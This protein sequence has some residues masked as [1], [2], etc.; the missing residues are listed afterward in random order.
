MPKGFLERNGVPPFPDC[1]PR[2]VTRSS[3]QRETTGKLV[4]GLDLTCASQCFSK[5][6]ETSRGLESGHL[7]FS[8]AEGGRSRAE[9]GRSSKGVG[10]SE[11]T[12]L[13]H[14]SPWFVQAE[15]ISFGWCTTCHAR[16]LAWNPFPSPSP[17]F[18]SGRCWIRAGTQF[19]PSAKATPPRRWQ[20]SSQARP[21]KRRTLMPI[22]STRSS[23]PHL[24]IE[25]PR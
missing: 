12:L 17:I 20:A 15:K 22:C 6:L 9:G 7:T 10:R 23:S 5:L 25:G 19:A 3:H 14:L 13:M 4:T 21:S 11:T 16:D 8:R 1:V 24:R 2:V 18:H